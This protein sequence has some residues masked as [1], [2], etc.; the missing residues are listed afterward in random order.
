MLPIRVLEM[1]ENILRWYRWCANQCSQI[2]MK[3]NIFDALL[4]GM[5]CL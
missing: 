5:I 4:H 1:A 3:E 2:K